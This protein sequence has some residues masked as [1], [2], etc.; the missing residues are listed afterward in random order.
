MNNWDPS[1]ETLKCLALEGY[2]NPKNISIIKVGNY[3][4]QILDSC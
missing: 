2:Q 3:E 4:N 1:L